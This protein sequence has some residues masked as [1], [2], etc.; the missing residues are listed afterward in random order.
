M[1]ARKDLTCCLFVV[2]SIPPLAMHKTITHVVEIL[3]N[4]GGGKRRPYN[5]F[6]TK[7]CHPFERTNRLHVLASPNQQVTLRSFF[8]NN[9]GF[10]TKSFVQSL[11][12]FPQKNKKKEHEMPPKNHWMIFLLSLSLLFVF[13]LGCEDDGDDDPKTCADGDC[14]TSNYDLIFTDWTTGPTLML[15]NSGNQRSRKLLDLD[16]GIAAA[17]QVAVNPAGDR[18]AYVTWEDDSWQLYTMLLS[19]QST[20]L[21]VTI[22]GGADALPGQPSFGPDG[23][24]I[25]Y[26]GFNGQPNLWDVSIVDLQGNTNVIAT[27]HVPGAA[28]APCVRPDWSPDGDKMIFSGWRQENGEGLLYAVDVNARE[29]TEL[30]DPPGTGAVCRA[31]WS[32]AGTEIAFI[33]FFDTFDTWALS[34]M[35]ADGSSGLTFPQLEGGFGVGQIQWSPDDSAIVYVDYDYSLSDTALYTVA[36]ADG[37]ITQ[38]TALDAGVEAGHPQWS[39]DGS[40]IAFVMF[41]VDESNARLMTIPSDGGEAKSVKLLG[42]GI[43]AGHPQWLPVPVE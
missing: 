21:L 18:I 42:T 14:D 30:H 1:P 13:A 40:L 32:H 38:L 23:T 34:R 26:V 35:A 17:G 37:T 25:A 8:L 6:P 19:D 39:P 29:L 3:G 12:V 5:R 31:V 36:V 9:L 43:A 2:L 7:I 28:M 4:S 22:D 15:A 10:C 33:S 41:D 11:D 27:I 20:T 16:G 24:K